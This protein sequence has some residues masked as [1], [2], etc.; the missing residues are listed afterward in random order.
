LVKKE[1]DHALSQ[2]STTIH[3][4]DAEPLD[5]IREESTDG[6]DLAGTVAKRADG[7]GACDA[8]ASGD[9]LEGEAIAS[10]VEPAGGDDAIRGARALGGPAGP[11]CARCGR[12]VDEILPNAGIEAVVS[13]TRSVA[14]SAGASKEVSTKRSFAIVAS[15]VPDTSKD[16]PRREEERGP[17]MIIHRRRQPTIEQ[18]SIAPELASLATLEVAADTAILALAAAHPDLQDGDRDLGDD[19]AVVRAAFALIDV[20]RALGNTLERYRW[21]LRRAGSQNDD[22]PF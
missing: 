13:P 9:P 2:E 11:R 16:S 5:A 22:I 10:T 8:R 1:T 17:T 18:L 14:D 21:A 15:F 19:S 7:A 3:G 20:A 4:G 6:I 12:I